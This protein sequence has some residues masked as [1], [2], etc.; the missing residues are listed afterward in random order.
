MKKLVPYISVIPIPPILLIPIPPS[1]IYVTKYERLYPTGKYKIESG[2]YY[3]DK[4]FVQHKGWFFKHW[5]DEDDI[6]FFPEETSK[7]FTCK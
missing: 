6:F 2:P 3:Q 4:I 1:S 7:T 5:I